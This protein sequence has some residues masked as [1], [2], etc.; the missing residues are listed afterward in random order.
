MNENHSQEYD[1]NQTIEKAVQRKQRSGN[2]TIDALA[3]TIPKGDSA[4]QQRLEDSLIAHLQTEK[5]E[6]EVYIMTKR[7]R[8]NNSRWPVTLAAAVLA[9]I[10]VGG[11][12]L[13]MPRGESQS[14]LAGQDTN[15]PF[16]MTATALVE[17]ATQVALAEAAT[18]VP[19]DGMV[20]RAKRVGI[21]VGH[22]GIAGDVGAS[23][24]DGLTELTVNQSIADALKTELVNQ[25]YRVDTFDEMAANLEAYSGDM[26]IALHTGDCLNASS[27]GFSF[28]W[29][30]TDESAANCILTDYAAATG[31]EAISTSPDMQDTYLL[32]Q[33]SAS[34]A[35]LLLEMGSLAS[36]RTLLTDEKDKVVRGIVNSVNCVLKTTT[37]TSNIPPAEGCETQD[38]NIITPSNGIIVHNRFFVYGSAMGDN[39]SAAQ[40]EIAGPS[41]NG[42]FI[43][44][45]KLSE[46]QQGG[47]LAV[48]NPNLTPLEDGVYQ[49]RLS[50]FNKD[51][52]LIASCTIHIFYSNEIPGAPA[53]D[54]FSEVVLAKQTIPAGTTISLDMLITV[55][56]DQTAFL[57]LPD[58]MFNDM[59]LLDGRVANIDI[60]S[61]AIITESMLTK[62][63]VSYEANLA[64]A[65]KMTPVVIALK[66][67]A[68]GDIISEDMLTISYLPQD[69]ALNI[70]RANTG[71][72][73][74]SEIDSL[75]GKQ[76]QTHI[77]PFEPITNNSVAAPN[78]TCH[79]ICVDV[80]D[81]TVSMPIDYSVL[82]LLADE[83]ATR[84]VPGDKVDVIASFLFTDRA[85]DGTYRADNGNIKL[86]S[87][88]S[89][90]SPTLVNQRVAEAL[91]LIKLQETD[92]GV[93]ALIAVPP[94][95]PILDNSILGGNAGSTFMIVPHVEGSEGLNEPKIIPISADITVSASSI[96]VIVP[97]QDIPY[98]EIITGDMVT[99]AYFP[100][101]SIN[102]SYFTMIGSVIGKQAQT[103]LRPYEPILRNSV[104]SPVRPEDCLGS[105]SSSRCTNG[106]PTGTNMGFS[107]LT[108]DPLVTQ[109]TAG[110][111]VDVVTLIWVEQKQS[112]EYYDPVITNPIYS[113][114]DKPLAIM[115][116]HSIKGAVFIGANPPNENGEREVLLAAD[117]KYDSI[118]H[119]IL[120]RNLP[121]MIVP[122]IAGSEE[123]TNE[124]Q[125]NLFPSSSYGFET[126]NDEIT[127]YYPPHERFV[128]DYSVLGTD[129]KAVVSFLI[130]ANTMPE[131]LQGIPVY[132]LPSGQWILSFEATVQI[133]SRSQR[134]EDGMIEMPQSARLLL[135]T[136]QAGWLNQLDIQAVDYIYTLLPVASS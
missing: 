50:S 37:E 90:A 103:H 107:L 136:T 63:G 43:L 75:I 1:L 81:G 82:S 74:Y 111:L 132:Y 5:T 122:H 126:Q 135:T 30:N 23:C 109:M 51:G 39:F 84:L 105:D 70:A 98:G 92:Q 59:R 72:W 53:A 100:Q 3:Q 40:I 57:Y 95:T 45:G 21:V 42:A 2:E 28:A 113:N 48:F 89:F 20:V 106:L 71:V 60:P 19:I 12:L 116:D 38:A 114:F 120:D 15:N 128:G 25:G 44:L 32:Q 9:I 87:I 14:A 67:I 65:G 27:N 47:G 83:A 104:I 93:A 7:K 33:V 79:G 6:K 17:K 119:E 54:D 80:P 13:L 26:L 31:L 66:D 123:D 99:T 18:D 130:S 24:E 10:V 29:S 86:G 8:M 127:A 91:T 108:K 46:P 124:P 52:K 64:S 88:T 77:R 76:A 62:P 133:G 129:K 125:I 118:S 35:V 94:N 102:D 117:D 101:N 58:G 96:P 73:Y 112:S 78:T 134:R 56:S 85:E 69:K 41:T 22:Q 16:D 68:L 4:F 49:L 121:F 61:N 34:T 36:D 55:S 131:K 97:V 11:F 115:S 110:D